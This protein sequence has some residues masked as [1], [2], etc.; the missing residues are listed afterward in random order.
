[1]PN[2][3][4]G[5]DGSPRFGVLE[6]SALATLPQ[7]VRHNGERHP[8]SVAYRVRRGGAWVESTWR[9]VFDQLVVLASGLL[10][11]VGN[12]AIV[13][14]LPVG[15][16]VGPNAPEYFV[17]EYAIQAIG[18]TAFPLFAGVT[19]GEMCDVL[20]SY[21][22]MVAFSYSADATER[23]LA[24][25]SAIGLP[26]IVHGGNEVA[27]E[28]PKI[29]T[30]RELE[31]LG[32]KRMEEKPEEIAWHIDQGRFEDIAC[33]ILTSG[34]TGTSKGVLGSHRYLLDVA[35]RYRY[36]YRAAVGDRYLSYLPAAFSVEQYNGLALAAGLRLEVVFPESPESVERDFI[37]GEIS[38]KYL[39]PRQW[40]A[41]RSMLPSD[42]LSDVERIRARKEKI[43][44]ELGLQYVKAGVTA[45]GSMSSEV[46]DFFRAIDVPICNV[47]GNAEIGIAT[48][49]GPESPADSVGIPFP[50]AYGE[51]IAVRVADDGE[52]QF[53][54]GVWSSGYWGDKGLDITEDG[55]LRTGDAGEISEGVLRIIDRLDNIQVLADGSVFAPQA[56]ETR[57]AEC[58]YVSN[59]VVFRGGVD[60]SGMGA[61][62]QLNV[63][64]ICRELRY[65]EDSDY[66]V[67]LGDSGAIDLVRRDVIGINATLPMSHRVQS[68]G[69]LPKPLTVEDEELTRSLKLRRGEVLRRYRQLVDKMWSVESSE[70][71]GA[72]YE[73]TV[74]SDNELKQIQAWSPMFTV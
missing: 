17:S 1:M 50:S 56:I 11:V 65:P 21:H 64:A 38:M 60:E 30:V 26:I 57:I 41:L 73:C 6:K 14:E 31:K 49:A 34:T 23:L 20:A 47:Y 22:P 52:V 18:A 51:R 54:G 37:A 28:D 71:G 16:V 9:R 58:P 10:E 74:G 25:S 24:A 68:V 70:N 63:K 40:E 2:V 8:D 53:Q 48:G 55:W 33:I 44:K 35:S 29:L 61:V 27:P 39:G 67:V 5:P 66:G 7:I 69:V 3:L 19:V 13:G 43:R 36:A 62:V 45:G 46:V 32:R 15:Y 4:L 12:P 42:L 59:V 72:T